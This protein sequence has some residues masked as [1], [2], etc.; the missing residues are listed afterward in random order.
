MRAV[1]ASLARA[2]HESGPVYATQDVLAEAEA[3]DVLA[4]RYGFVPQG[5]VL[6]LFRDR[7]FHEP[8]APALQ[9]RGVTDGAVR[10]ERDDVARRT[11]LPAMLRM[12]TLR[13]LYLEVSGRAERARKAFDEADRFRSRFGLDPLPDL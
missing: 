11:V 5:L 8:L 2:G 1:V 12:L 9:L 10:L 7:R 4:P 3:V 13:A 6:Q